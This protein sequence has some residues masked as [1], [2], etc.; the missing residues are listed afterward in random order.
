VVDTA[1]RRVH[2]TLKVSSRDDTYSFDVVY[3]GRW[4][5]ADPERVVRD[6]VHDGDGTV[7]DFLGNRLGMFARRFDRDD[8]TGVATQIHDTISLPA[9]VE[10]KGVAVGDGLAL[11][12]LAVTVTPDPRVAERKVALDDDFN[13]G[14]LD[15]R[16]LTRLRH[17]LDGDGSAIL[18]HL[19]RNPDDSGTVLKMI[20]DARDKSERT[21]LEWLDRM[22]EDGAIQEA[23]YEH[24][25]TV[26]LGGGPVPQLALDS[27]SFR[28]G[29]GP[30]PRIIE[31]GGSTEAPARPSGNPFPTDEPGSQPTRPK[32]EDP[33]PFDSDPFRAATEPR[34]DAHQGADASPF[35]RPSTPAERTPRSAAPQRD[36]PRAPRD[37]RAHRLKGGSVAIQWRAAG[38]VEYRVRRLDDAR[39]H[40]V[41]TTTDTFIEDSDAPPGAVPVY[42][43]SADSGGARSAE[44]RSDA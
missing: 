40:E 20:T 43:V 3:D 11:I 14:T 24:T 34:E 2:G 5:V 16:R 23:D 32:P 31:A 12:A 29:P 22:R 30:Q 39:W 26:I 1:P 10:E 4:R 41:A 38:D 44:T 18:Y 27:N 8:A 17:L 7:A 9:E 19:A 6:N 42:S 37:V 25:R 21:R 28:T 13:K 35:S 33:P 15:E 36:A